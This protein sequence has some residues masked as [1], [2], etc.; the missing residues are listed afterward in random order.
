MAAKWFSIGTLDLGRD[1]RL[2]CDI[3]NG[4]YLMYDAVCVTYQG[5][6]HDHWGNQYRACPACADR[7]RA[8]HKATAV[9][10]ELAQEPVLV[11]ASAGA[12]A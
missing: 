11:S 1:I 4:E 10:L 3:C 8:R 6:T 7:L 12:A 5:R 2:I 9:Q